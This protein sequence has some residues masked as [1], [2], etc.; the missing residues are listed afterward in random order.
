MSEKESEAPARRC[1]LYKGDQAEIFE[2]DDAIAAAEKDGWTDTP[3]GKPKAKKKA[4]KKS[5]NQ[6]D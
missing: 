2:G 5:P 4:S 6:D 1:Y 3:G